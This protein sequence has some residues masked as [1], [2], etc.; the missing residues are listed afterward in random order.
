M[1]Y[2]AL[3]FKVTKKYVFVIW[4]KSAHNIGQVIENKQLTLLLYEYPKYDL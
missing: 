2:E 1:F 4:F 3:K